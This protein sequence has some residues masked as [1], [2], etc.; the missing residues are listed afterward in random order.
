MANLEQCDRIR[1]SLRTPVNPRRPY[2]SRPVALHHV[3]SHHP[4]ESEA[5]GYFR[6]CFALPVPTMTFRTHPKAPRKAQ[7]STLPHSP[8][9]PPSLG[10]CCGTSGSPGG[11]GDKNGMD[12]AWWGRHGAGRAPACLP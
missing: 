3:G 9:G 7:T 11:P 2:G 10:Y 6:W 1:Q 5:M 8:T 4:V 12:A